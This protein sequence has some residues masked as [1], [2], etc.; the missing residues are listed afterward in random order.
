MINKEQL[1]AV[2][3][4]C[5]EYSP[6]KNDNSFLNYS[7][8]SCENCSHYDGNRCMINVYDKVLNGLDQS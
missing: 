7:G 1:M 2:A 6:K 3:A 5:S 4:S 8:V